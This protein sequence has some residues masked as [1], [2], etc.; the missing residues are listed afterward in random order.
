MGIRINIAMGWGFEKVKQK[1]PRFTDEFLKLWHEDRGDILPELKS[2]IEKV[3]STK[4][5]DSFTQTDASMILQRINGTGWYEQK[6]PMTHLTVYDVIH[7]SG[8]AF[9][10]RR[11]A[12]LVFVPIECDDW[13]RH[14]DIIDYY[15][16]GR[17]PKDNVEIITD[18]SGYPCPIYPHALY[19]N[20]KNGKLIYHS[21]EICRIRDMYKREGL[22]KTLEEIFNDKAIADL[23]A[24]GITTMEQLYTDMVPMVPYSIRQFCKTFNVFKDPLEVNNL[25]PMIYTYW[26]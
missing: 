6:K 5:D 21:T 22:T 16:A 2:D 4:D 8:Y 18:G 13:Y 20:R 24:S 9:E 3:A 7:M 11:L 25:V 19:V 23:N 17:C 10:G 14:D 1:D 15:K 26:C 12:P